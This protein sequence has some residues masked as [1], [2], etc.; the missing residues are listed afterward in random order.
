MLQ[1]FTETEL[2]L[3][4]MW[5]PFPLKG[6]FVFKKT[7]DSGRGKEI[8]QDDEFLIL[9]EFTCRLRTRMFAIDESL[10]AAS[11]PGVSRLVFVQRGVHGVVR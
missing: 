2:W 7:T 3:V 4:K 8:A 5:S 11:T 6:H 9:N 1:I 10:Q